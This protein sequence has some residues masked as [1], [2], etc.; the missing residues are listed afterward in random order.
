MREKNNISIEIKDKWILTVEEASAYSS[1]GVRRLQEL[2]RDPSC[3]FVLRNGSK[4]L[5]KRK[6]FEEYLDKSY[7]I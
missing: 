6:E 7:A 3:K 4:K 1:I 2:L 5:V